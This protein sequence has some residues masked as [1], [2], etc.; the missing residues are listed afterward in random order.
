M[1]FLENPSKTQCQFKIDKYG[2]WHF[3][4]QLDVSGVDSSHVKERR[5]NKHTLWVTKNSVLHANNIKKNQQKQALLASLHSL[6]SVTGVPS[7]TGPPAKKQKGCSKVVPE[8]SCVDL[9]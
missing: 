4:Q 1:L 6:G 8:S 7:E 9:S 5:G 3:Y 2:R